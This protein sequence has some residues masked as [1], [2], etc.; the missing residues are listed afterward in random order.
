MN[1]NYSEFIEKN[2]YYPDIDYRDIGWLLKNSHIE[3]KE[4]SYRGLIQE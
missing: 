3:D 4:F 1:G 2:G